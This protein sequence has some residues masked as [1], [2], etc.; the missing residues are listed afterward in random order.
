MWF[1]F[2]I[3]WPLSGVLRQ[4]QALSALLFLY[5]T[6]L[7]QPLSRIVAERAKKPRKLPVVLVRAD[8]VKLLANL[9]GQHWLI[10]CLLYGSGLR[11]MEAV[12]LRG[13]DLDF[14]Y[15]A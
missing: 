6:V 15:R 4:N 12:R 10:G 5:G 8:V 3:I 2:S 13:K 14:R 11:L 7:E 9:Q 1:G